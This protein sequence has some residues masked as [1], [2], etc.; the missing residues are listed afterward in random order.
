MLFLHYFED[1]S[2]CQKLSPMPTGIDDAMS[3]RQKREVQKTMNL[4][5]KYHIKMSKSTMGLEL[6]D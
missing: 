1:W 3:A 5:L 6:M 2:A 4:V